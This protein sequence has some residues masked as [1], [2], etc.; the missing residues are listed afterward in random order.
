MSPVRKWDFWLF[1]LNLVLQNGFYSRHYKAR[2]CMH[3]VADA[4]RF[5]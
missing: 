1:G 4:S 3:E 2:W 5:R